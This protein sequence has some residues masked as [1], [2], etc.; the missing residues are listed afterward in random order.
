MNAVGI[1][2]HQKWEQPA[3]AL[4]K[5]NSLLAAIYIQYVTQCQVTRLFL[6]AAKTQQ[7][8]GN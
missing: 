4:T 7:L 2:K 8:T 6:R 1:E 3:T 5:T